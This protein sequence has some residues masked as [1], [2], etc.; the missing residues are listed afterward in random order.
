MVYDL[1]Q[2]ICNYV[3]AKKADAK[4]Q[5]TQWLTYLM[6][7]SSREFYKYMRAMRSVLST[8]MLLL[9]NITII[10]PEISTYVTDSYESPARLFVTGGGGGGGGKEISSNEGTMQGDPITMGIY[11]IGIIPL[12]S[13]LKSTCFRT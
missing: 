3:Q 7:T 4:L 2:E 12:L 13:R 10:C 6:M 11:A 1:V 9:H 5:F 8:E